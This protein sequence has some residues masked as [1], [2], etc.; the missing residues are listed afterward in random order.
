MRA[1]QL[2]RLKSILLELEECP[3]SEQSARLL[4][5]VSD[6]PEILA[7][8]QSLLSQD[9]SSRILQALISRIMPDALSDAMADAMADANSGAK[10]GA[11]APNEEHHSAS[12]EHRQIGP[13]RLLDRLGAGGMGVVWRAEQLEPIRRL[14]ALKILR[15][16]WDIAAL[17]VRFEA[18]RRSLALMNHPNI[19]R[20]FDAGSDEQ[21]QPFFVMELVEGV[22]ISDFVRQRTLTPDECLALFVPVC[23]AV[24]HAHQRGIIHRD[25]KPTNI[26]VGETDG[27]AIPKVIDFGIAKTL[28]P[29]GIGEGV[30]TM[31]G[32]VLGT[33]EYMSPE[34]ARGISGEVDT[35]ADIFAL[36]AILS[37]LLTG[38][39]PRDFR[40]RSVTDSLR[41]LV[42]I[43]IVLP[44]RSAEGRAPL[45]D[46][47]ITIIRKATEPDADRRYGSAG[48]LADDLERFRNS[49]PI[50]A[51]PPDAAYQLRKLVRRHRVAVAFLGVVGAA[52]LAVGLTLAFLLAAERRALRGAEL[53]RERA[54]AIN[55]FMSEVLASPVPGEQGRDVRVVDAMDRALPR[56][57]ETFRDRPE[58]RVSVERRMASSYTALGE[59]GRCDSL[60]FAA[61]A[62]GRR[63][64]GD[65][66]NELRLLLTCAGQS[67]HQFRRLAQADSLFNEA[68]SLGFLAEPA[69]PTELVQLM[70]SRAMIRF[71]RG[72]TAEA[73]SLLQAGISLAERHGSEKEYGMLHQ[74]LAFV[75]HSQGRLVDARTE[76][77]RAIAHMK[78]AGRPGEVQLAQAYTLMA[79]CLDV[80]VDAALPDSLNLASL[81]LRRK[82]QMDGP[83]MS[84]LLI[85]ISVNK[86]LKGQLASAE[87]LQLEALG[88]FEAELGQDNNVVVVSLSNLGYAALCRDDPAAALA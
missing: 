66:P 27:H 21:G 45:D 76:F 35:R 65:D 11:M 74:N 73:E 41:T 84:T 39:P 56:L 62:L 7:E 40:D 8:A 58:L 4:E 28:D 50:A 48:A 23:R 87:S 43:P 52:L 57:A 81:A 14:V 83:A 34:Q 32:Q 6:D 36:G 17:R 69:D 44:S 68:W 2:E 72:S 1:D 9:H 22:P 51:R 49:E 47:L 63:V 26:L 88:R 64:L 5:M 13:Y 77:R 29:D 79:I 61:L 85:N 54:E 70:R 12:G 46:D 10:S 71:D 55:S 19:A 42:D 38:R 31:D 37:E 33:L 59:A 3:V 82:H 67:A 60:A 53:E 24:Q 75:Y 78:R 86:L 16:G 30:G 15:G 25:L 20:M 18:E 80:G